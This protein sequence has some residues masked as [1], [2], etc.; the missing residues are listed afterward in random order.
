VTEGE[1]QDVVLKLAALYGWTLTYHTYDSTRSNPGWPD[2]V[3]HRPPGELLVVE[4]KSDKGRV[5]PAQQEWLAALACS[6]VETAVWRPRDLDDVVHPRLKRRP[7]RPW[8]PR[9]GL[10]VRPVAVPR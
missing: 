7:A 6:G 3:L 10:P 9:G 8:S 1:W 2:L 5:K 4:L